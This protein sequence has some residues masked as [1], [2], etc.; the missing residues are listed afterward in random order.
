MVFESAAV[1]VMMPAIASVTFIPAPKSIVPIVPAKVPL[2]FTIRD[3]APPP[4]PATFIRPEP[5]PTKL[6]AVI[7]PLIL[8]PV[9]VK[10]PTGDNN[11]ALVWDIICA[12]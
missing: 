11:C 10:I 4:P 2:S 7:M 9:P 1:T 3:P 5:S 12:F 6:V 8:I